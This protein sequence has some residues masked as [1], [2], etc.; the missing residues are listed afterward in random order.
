MTQETERR[1]IAF[2]RTIA[3]RCTSCLRRNADT[4]R[5]CV[6][7]W[8]NEIMTD[9]ERELSCESGGPTQDYS[10]AARMLM[11]ADALRKAGRPLAANEIDM[12]GCCSKQ[13]KY[14]T[15]MR[16]VRLGFIARDAG[17]GPP[18]R[19]KQT[20]KAFPAVRRT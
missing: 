8:A 12:Q 7:S 4:C 19:Y 10:L 17:D 15:L 20:A 9:Y 6:S 2:I 11:V 3:N 16:M 14:W 5:N 18:Y 13:L 1:A